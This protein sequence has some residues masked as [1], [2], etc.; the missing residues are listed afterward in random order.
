MRTSIKCILFIVLSAS[1][2]LAADMKSGWFTTSDG[3]KIHFIEAGQGKPI[4]FIPGWTMAA[5]IWQPQI[6]F[7]PDKYHVIA[8]DPRSQGESDK[9]A[10]GNYA[11]R[12]ARDYKE[13]VDHLKLEKPVLVGW[14]MAVG[15]VLSYVDQFGADNLRGVVL[16]DG[17]IKLDPAQTGSFAAFFKTFVTDRKGATAAFVK[18]MYKKPQDDNYL[19]KVTEASLKTPTNS[20]M[21]LI[22]AAVGTPDLSGVLPKMANIPVLYEYQVSSQPQADIVKEKLPSATLHRYSDDG[23]ALFVDD[24]KRF[25]R[26]VNEMMETAK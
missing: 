6:D 13:L 1:T 21:A 23:H 25:N 9:P 2:L 10:D 18:G 15:E 11:E 19:A 4:V 8:V 12:R 26:V 14:S 16:V 22:F 20:A 7:F 3:I 5:D 17:L 24:S